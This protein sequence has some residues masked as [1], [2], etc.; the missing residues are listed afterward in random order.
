VALGQHQATFLVHVQT[1]SHAHLADLSAASACIQDAGG[2]S[3]TCADC[4]AANGACLNQECGLQCASIAEGPSSCPTCIRNSQ[5]NSALSAC[6]GMPL[7]ACTDPQD[8]AAL[9]Q[10][11]G[12]FLAD[13]EMCSSTSSN[14][15]ALVTCIQ[16]TGGLTQPCALCYAQETTCV[17]GACPCDPPDSSMCPPCIDEKCTPAFTL[18]SGIPADA[19]P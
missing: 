16:D 15:D 4:Y 7:Y 5:C 1:C 2:I 10:D 17:A 13:L 8:L 3:N 19:G 18:C 12:A 6:T 14:E 9:G 11:A